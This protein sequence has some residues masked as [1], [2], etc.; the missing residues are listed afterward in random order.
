MFRS[1]RGCTVSFPIRKNTVIMLLLPSTREMSWF[2]DYRINSADS[3]IP[4]IAAISALE[5]PFS[6]SF[7]ATSRAL[8]NSPSAL[9]S[10]LPSARPAALPS[11]MLA[12]LPSSSCLDAPVWSWILYPRSGWHICTVCH[13]W[14]CKGFRQSPPSSLVEIFFVFWVLLMKLKFKMNV[15][16]KA[17]CLLIKNVH[18]P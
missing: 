17:Q 6:S 2:S 5:S 11:A 12:A 8:A 16:K 1:P 3:S 18:S 10:A 15:N 7:A 4:T 9:P 13:Q 14:T